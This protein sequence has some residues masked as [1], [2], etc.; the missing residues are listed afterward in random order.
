M[1]YIRVEEFDEFFVL[2]QS[3]DGAWNGVMLTDTHEEFTQ[4][5]P[6]RVKLHYIHCL[7]LLVKI[8]C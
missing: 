6:E 2:E 1:T 4:S 3:V 5:L 7:R 8:C